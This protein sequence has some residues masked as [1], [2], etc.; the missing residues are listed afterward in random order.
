MNLFLL[1]LLAAVLITAAVIDIRTMV[2]PDVV[3]LCILGL[4]LVSLFTENGPPLASR[5]CASLTIGGAMLLVSILT[6]GGIGGGDIKLMASSGL[7]LGL[8]RNLL[9][10]ILA[11]ITAGL[12]YAVP[13]F[14]GKIDR[15]RQVPMIPYF[16]AAI[17]VSYLFGDRIIS[18]YLQFFVL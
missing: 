11:Y 16:A 15:N 2:V 13:L 10:L 7:L 9:A 14:L 6:K 17:L 4:A 18:W 1:I 12:F 3:H 8:P 5:V